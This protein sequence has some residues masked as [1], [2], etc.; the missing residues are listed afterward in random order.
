MLVKASS[1]N[2]DNLNP[3]NPELEHKDTASVIRNKLT[4]LL[5]ELRGF[6]FL[7]TLVIELKSDDEAKYTT[8]YSNSKDHY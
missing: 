7:K 2:V 8:F 1:Y 3:F 5:T 6:T 4:D